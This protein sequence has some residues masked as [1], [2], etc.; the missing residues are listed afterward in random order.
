MFSKS[1]WQRSR[2]LGRGF[3]VRFLTPVK[4][5]VVV[6]KLTPIPNNPAFI[7][8]SLC[9]RICLPTGR[10]GTKRDKTMM[11]PTGTIMARKINKPRG[12]FASRYGYEILRS[13]TLKVWKSG[14]TVDKASAT[15]MATLPN[16]HSFG[17]KRIRNLAYI[18]SNQ[19]TT[20]EIT[21]CLE[22]I[23]D[24]LGMNTL[25]CQGITVR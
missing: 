10:P 5:T 7:S 19:S 20:H 12:T 22:V 17:C 25:C 15:M 18:I 14:L 23:D 21:T 6:A 3:P 24:D 2:K 8:Q 9:R 11:R 1:G 16:C 13:S 4:M